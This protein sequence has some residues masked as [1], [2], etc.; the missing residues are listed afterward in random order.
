MGQTG[1]EKKDVHREVNERRI[2]REG[3][4]EREKPSLRK[5]E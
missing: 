3:E 2:E 5:N 1:R 4:R